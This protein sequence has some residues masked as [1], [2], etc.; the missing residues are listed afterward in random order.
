MIRFTEM[1]LAS[2]MRVSAAI[3]LI[4]A[5]SSYL[6]ASCSVERYILKG[7]IID[8]SSKR[9]ISGAMTL[10]F[11]DSSEAL[12]CRSVTSIDGAFECSFPFSSFRRNGWF[13]GKADICDKEPEIF[14]IVVIKD[15]YVPVKKK[16]T[17][18]QVTISSTATHNV[19]LPQISL[20]KN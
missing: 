13:F 4:L 12:T 15:A 2:R 20:T 1:E 9:R 7:V 14:E 6:D 16:F 17:R 10:V 19:D 18:K 3:V 8:D 11:V 5:I